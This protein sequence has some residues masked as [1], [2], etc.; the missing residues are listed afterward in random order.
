[1]MDTRIKPCSR[2]LASSLVLARVESVCRRQRASLH[3]GL[4]KRIDENRELLECLQRE[5]PELMV[6]CPWIAGWIA[7]QDSFLVDMLNALGWLP[8]CPSGARFPR[9]WPKNTHWSA[10][11]QLSAYRK[12]S[13]I[14]FRIC[15]CWRCEK[16][17]G[18]LCAPLSISHCARVIPSAK[19]KRQIFGV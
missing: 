2:L 4:Y 1:M 19:R 15:S 3:K 11:T 18:K 8:T 12:F 10:A 14:R 5:A 17:I 16:N 13:P 9:P 6:R 7:G